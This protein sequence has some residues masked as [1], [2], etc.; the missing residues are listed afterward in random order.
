LSEASMEKIDQ[1]VLQADVSMQYQVLIAKKD[2][3][4]PDSGVIS[5]NVASHSFTLRDFTASS[6][7]LPPHFASH[8]F[9]RRSCAQRRIRIVSMYNDER[10]DFSTQHHF[11]HIVLSSISSCERK[12]APCGCFARPLAM[13]NM[14]EQF[15]SDSH[16]FVTASK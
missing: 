2:R 7:C 15:S 8:V 5:S 12:R 14:S 1:S 3:G 11:F 10:C 9:E 13:A 4:I 16:G 6:S